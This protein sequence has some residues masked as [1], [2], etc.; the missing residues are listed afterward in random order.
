MLAGWGRGEVLDNGAAC[1][2]GSLMSEV[3]WLEF[4]GESAPLGV[5][6]SKS[7]GQTSA[8]TVDQSG[9]PQGA[10]LRATGVVLGKVREVLWA[11]S[12]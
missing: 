10:G 12:Q 6:F 3:L 9:T 4:Q 2:G 7:G 8:G 1:L 11:C 5:V